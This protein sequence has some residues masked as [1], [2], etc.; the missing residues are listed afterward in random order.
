P[1]SATGVVRR[2]P[3]MKWFRRDRDVPEL[4]QLHS[5]I[6]YAIWPH[7]KSGGTLVYATGSVLPE[8]N[9]LQSKA[10]LQR[11]AAAELCET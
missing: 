9:S 6:L 1:C 5:E 11:T 7:L 3:D 8:D 4:A 2:H 10:F